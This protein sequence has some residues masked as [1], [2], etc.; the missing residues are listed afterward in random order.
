LLLTP[1]KSVPASSLMWGEFVYKHA[2]GYCRGAEMSE[3]IWA[4]HAR[5]SWIL[6]HT[7]IL[8]SSAGQR[9]FTSRDLLATI[10]RAF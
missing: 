5:W 7:V 3:S 2:G 4:R 10:T 6:L 1:H 8:H 9:C